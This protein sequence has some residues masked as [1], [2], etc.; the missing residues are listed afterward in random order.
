MALVAAYG[1][2][3]LKIK[4]QYLLLFAIFIESVAN[5]SYDFRIK[6]TERYK[7]TLENLEC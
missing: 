6:P 2:T 4:L 3:F 1:I 7:L 5:Q